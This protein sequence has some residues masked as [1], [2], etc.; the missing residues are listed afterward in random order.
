MYLERRLIAAVYKNNAHFDFSAI[1]GWSHLGMSYYKPL[2][3]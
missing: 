3:P 1:I 2:N